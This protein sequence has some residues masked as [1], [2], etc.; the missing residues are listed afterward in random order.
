MVENWSLINKV[1]ITWF[2]F[3]SNP[4]I[5]KIIYLCGGM[6]MKGSDFG[7][8][9]LL[10]KR[11]YMSFLKVKK[12]MSFLKVKKNMSYYVGTEKHELLCR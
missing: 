2:N 3:L 9:F 8:C 5:G 10:G 7:S 12:N 1:Y 11:K 6:D 4:L